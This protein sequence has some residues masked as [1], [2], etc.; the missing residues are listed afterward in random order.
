METSPVPDPPALAINRARALDGL[1]RLG[2]GT[3]IA[4]RSELNRAV[5]FAFLAPMPLRAS[6]PFPHP[7]VVA[8]KDLFSHAKEVLRRGSALAKPCFPIGS[9]PIT[10]AAGAAPTLLP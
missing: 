9:L 1:L 4:H 2:S 5:R 7:A 8:D 10:G 3:L 6:K